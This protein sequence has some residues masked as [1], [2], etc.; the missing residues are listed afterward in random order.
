MNTHD[1][2]ETVQFDVNLT[3][4]CYAMLAEDF[5]L[6]FLPVIKNYNLK[7]VREN[8]PWGSSD[9]SSVTLEGTRQDLGNYFKASG[10]KGLKELIAAGLYFGNYE[11]EIV[12]VTVKMTN[13]QMPRRIETDR[14]MEAILQDNQKISKTAAGYIIAATAPQYVRVEVGG[15]HMARQMFGAE[16]FPK[17]EPKFVWFRRNGGANDNW[18]LYGKVANIKRFLMEEMKK[19]SDE[20]AAISSLNA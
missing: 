4:S 9:V 14:E 16:L 1:P 12:S 15:Q 18:I 10:R 11:E 17:K 3:T 2:K 20:I 6:G 13:R 19:T 5:C 8:N 7:V